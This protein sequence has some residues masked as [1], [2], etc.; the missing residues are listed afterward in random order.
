M[1]PIS[2]SDLTPQQMNG[3]VAAGISVGTLYCFLGYRTLKILIALTGFSIAGLTAAT[4]AGMISEGEVPYMAFA[5]VTGG[6]FGAMALSFLYRTGVFFIGV[7]GAALVANN[8]LA[9][10][11]ETWVPLAVVGIGLVGGL[12]ALLIERPV[13]TVSSALIGSWIVV[14]GVAYFVYEASWIQEWGR[15]FSEY[16]GRNVVLTSWS[17]LAVAGTIAQVVTRKRAAA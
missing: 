9:Q 13:I 2:I 17:I 6:L 16:Q 12:V 14:S 7:L 4:M 3:I 10:Q 1:E 11:G 15:A 5:G 8:F